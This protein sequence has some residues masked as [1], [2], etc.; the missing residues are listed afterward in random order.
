MKRGRPGL[1]ERTLPIR[2]GKEFWEFKN[3]LK[4]ELTPIVG[5]VPSDRE[6]TNSLTRYLME[7]GVQHRIVRRA[8][9]LHQGKRRGLF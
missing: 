9:F 7:D 3:L 1:G 8:Q 5:R 2:V 4:T 6:I